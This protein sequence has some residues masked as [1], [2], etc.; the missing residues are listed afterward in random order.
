MLFRE[1]FMTDTAEAPAHTQRPFP[2]LTLG[3]LV[4]ILFAALT[5]TSNYLSFIP[6]E[7]A[8]GAMRVHWPWWRT[9]LVNAG[10]WMALLPFL[11]IIGRLTACAP[12]NRQH[13][14]RSLAKHGLA[15]LAL[16][17]L[18]FLMAW[19][20]FILT[21]ASISSWAEAMELI[22]QIPFRVMLSQLFAFP[23]NYAALAAISYA[24][25][26]H[27]QK[28]EKE[29]RAALLERQ[30][31]LAQLQML[32]MQLNPHFLF[33]T[34]NGILTLMRRDLDTAERM[35][36]ALTDFLRCTLEEDAKLETP[37]AHE[38]ETA[39]RYLAIECLRFP[40]RIALEKD[41]Q[42]EALQVA[43]PTL[44][45]QP[46]VENA[47]RHGLAPRAAG[48]RLKIQAHVRENVLHLAVEDDGVG[49]G[50]KSR[51]K[52]QNGGGVGLANTRERLFQ[53]YGTQAGFKAGARPE[54]GFR[55]ALCLPIPL[56][57]LEAKTEALA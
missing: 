5:A 34:L 18:H 19:G 48:G 4:L 41:I 31:A 43:I 2:P 27:R 57:L 39:A 29:H 47:V 53:R 50:A 38:L 12:L 46:L 3:L 37:L 10:Q 52:S 55:V 24:W 49:P 26:F 30:L 35:M 51:S 36:L 6:R 56:P 15:L 17:P 28:D 40:G 45:L 13:W 33:N 14:R 32:R 25:I 54:G 9:F 11:L 1:I 44:L 21:N 7:G 8:T 23:M 16:S 42:P 22:A 20:L